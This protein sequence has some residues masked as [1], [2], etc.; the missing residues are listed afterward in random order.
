MLLGKVLGRLINWEFYQLCSGYKYTPCTAHNM[1]IILI[2][3]WDINKI[4]SFQR[5]EQ[6]RGAL[7][8]ARALIRMIIVT[9]IVVCFIW[10]QILWDV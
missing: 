10:S 3:T 1:V 9:L 2:N 4:L 6:F 7:N 8:R 5:R